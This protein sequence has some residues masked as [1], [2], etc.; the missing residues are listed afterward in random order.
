MIELADT[1]EKLRDCF[2]VMAQ[3]RAHLDLDSFLKKVAQQAE[4]GYRVAYLK[5]DD[6]V[7]AVAGIRV[8]RNLAWGKFLYVDDLITDET[9][10]SKGYGKQ[11]LDWLISYAK[12]NDCAQLHLDSGVQ[13]KNAHRF[14]G[15]EGMTFTGHH[16][17]INL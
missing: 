1:E 17:A 5:A 12:E 16:Y 10:R 2:P 7:V 8:S 14:Y 3:L 6:K 11:C 15:R 4:A 13:R 9:E